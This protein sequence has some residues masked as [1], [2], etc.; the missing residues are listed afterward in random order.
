MTLSLNEKYK[1]V[2][3]FDL[4]C[5]IFYCY[6]FAER[7]SIVESFKIRSSNMLNDVRMKCWMKEGVNWSNM[8]ILLDEP[9]NVGLKLYLRSNFHPTQFSSIQYG[10]FFFF[11]IF[12]F[13]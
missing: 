5:V 7:F 12:A 6:Y 9:E 8:K 13:C 11:A 3:H 4:M 2:L 10:F 1:E